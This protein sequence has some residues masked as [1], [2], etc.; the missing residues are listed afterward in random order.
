MILVTSVENSWKGKQGEDTC[1]GMNIHM[2]G[3]R[4]R[5]GR[6]GRCGSQV[7]DTEKQDKENIV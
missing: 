1:M 7:P 4:N 2:S 3:G 6:S 5:S